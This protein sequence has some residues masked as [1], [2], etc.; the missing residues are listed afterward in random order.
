MPDILYINR[1]TGLLET[2]K[3][4]KEKALRLLYGESGI[5][6]FLHSWFLPLLAKHDAFSRFIGWLQKRPSSAKRILPFITTFEIDPSEFLDPVSSYHCFN[7]FF[8]RKLKPDARPIHSDPCKAMI[9]ADGRYYFYPNIEKCDGFL[10]K[11]KKFKLEALLASQALGEEFKEG[12][13]VIARLCPSDYHRFHF[14]C[15]GLPGSSKLINGWLYSVNPLA[16][17]QNIHIFT[18]NKRTLCEFHTPLFGKMLYLEIG[19]TTVG[20]IQQTY[21]PNEWQVK[22]EEKGYFEFGGSSLILLFAKQT[23]QFDAD[24]V[25]AT[26]QGI[27]IRCL[28]GQSMGTALIRSD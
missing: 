8:I 1:Q 7:D 24:L 19:A 3:V 6:H 10:V 11:G 14:P 25:D 21:Q 20:S 28:T 15:D 4:Y 22:G 13:M 5:A 12:S 9:P 27:E 16:V 2:E 18:E 26:N 23:I 17:K